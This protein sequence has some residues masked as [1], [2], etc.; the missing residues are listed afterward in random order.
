[1]A[2]ALGAR[3]RGKLRETEVRALPWSF[4]PSAIRCPVQAFHG[5]RDSLERLDDLERI[6]ARITDASV[7]VYPGGD[8]FSPLLHPER[9]VGAATGSAPSR[10]L[11][12]ALRNEGVLAFLDFR[13][14]ASQET[15]LDRHPSPPVRR[16]PAILA[17]TPDRGVC[18]R[19]RFAWRSLSGR[20]RGR[21]LASNDNRSWVYLLVPRAH[22]LPRPR[23]RHRAAGVGA[24]PQQRGVP[25]RSPP[26]A[27]GQWRDRSAGVRACAPKRGESAACRSDHRASWGVAFRLFGRGSD[28][29]RCSSWP[30]SPAVLHLQGLLPRA[31]IRVR[32]PRPRRRRSPCQL[33]HRT[34]CRP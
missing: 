29:G 30:F 23:G 11:T 3:A 16:A 17:P 27:L 21:G 2:A 20:G 12:H 24:I 6:L 31:L 7:T 14:G 18:R 5:D 33:R 13:S 1:M 4:D 32:P 15:A 19:L 34:P 28:G 25:S 9:L 10:V 8:H 22:R 26:V